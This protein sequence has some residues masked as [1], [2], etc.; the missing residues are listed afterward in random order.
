MAGAVPKLENG[1][2]VAVPP[3]MLLGAA[4]GDAAPLS[5]QVVVITIWVPDAA[6]FA[7]TLIYCEV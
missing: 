2:F 7:A 4:G 5:N 1:E 3:V 6:V